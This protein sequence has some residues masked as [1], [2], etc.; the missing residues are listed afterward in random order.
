MTLHLKV[1]TA[2]VSVCILLQ[3][4]CSIAQ[5][6][7]LTKVKLDSLIKLSNIQIK[8]LDPKKTEAYITLQEKFNSAQSQN[9]TLI[10]DKKSLNDKAKNIA[11]ENLKLMSN[12]ADCRLSS[13]QVADI[14]EWSK[15]QGIV[16]PAVLN[17]TIQ[18]SQKLD[19]TDLLFTKSPDNSTMK[20]INDNFDYFKQNL[21][22]VNQKSQIYKDL[23]KYK[24]VVSDYFKFLQEFDTLCKEITPDLDNSTVSDIVRIFKRDL[25]SYP[26]LRGAFY[27][28][29][30]Y[31][32]PYAVSDNFFWFLDNDV[33]IPS[34]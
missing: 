4:N 9:Q 29:S 28:A 30:E 16:L 14:T 21:E 15:V 22:L 12:L 6:D 19:E 8:L 7:S 26:Y 10:E 23:S 11:D 31:S 13:E 24:L 27:F 17:R 25:S 1:L 2:L 33:Q 5:Q 18:I 3:P 34:K 20:K 32:A